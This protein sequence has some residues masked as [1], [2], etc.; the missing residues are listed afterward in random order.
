MRIPNSWQHEHQMAYPDSSQPKP[1][2]PKPPSPKSKKTKLLVPTVKRPQDAR[3]VPDWLPGLAG[4]PPPPPLPK[5]AKSEHY[6][7]R[8]TSSDDDRTNDW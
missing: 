1:V 8:S 7:R 2:T 3:E 5:A 6:N 4:V